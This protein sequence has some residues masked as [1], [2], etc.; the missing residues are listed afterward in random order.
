[1]TDTHVFTRTPPVPISDPTINQALHKIE[2]M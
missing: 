1:M 2:I